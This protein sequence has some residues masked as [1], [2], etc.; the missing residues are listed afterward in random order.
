MIG[1]KAVRPP[2]KAGAQSRGRYRAC[3]CGVARIAE[4]ESWAPAFAGEQAKESGRAPTLSGR[5]REQVGEAAIVADVAGAAPQ[6]GLLAIGELAALLDGQGI[7]GGLKRAEGRDVAALEDVEAEISQRSIPGT[8]TIRPC[9]RLYQTDRKG[10]LMQ[11]AGRRGAANKFATAPAPPFPA[12]AAPTP[13]HRD[14]SRYP[15][16]A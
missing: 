12:F 10:V 15:G 11:V 16:A 13:S 9:N 1:R 5:P 4:K 8:G 6:F 3:A 7:V 2:G 14:A